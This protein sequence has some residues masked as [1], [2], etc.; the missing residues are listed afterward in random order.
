MK[1]LVLVATLGAL[2]ACSQPETASESELTEEVAVAET[3]S[4]A[5]DGMPSVGN[6]RVTGDDGTTYTQELRA[7]GTYTNTEE[8]KDDVTG[9][10]EQKSPEVFCTTK[11][12]EGAEQECSDENFGDDG[13]WKSVDQADGKV[14]TVERIES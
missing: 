11:G 5:L 1:N 6:Y 13:V 9:T 3:G 7:D 10:W 4:T 12:D 8:G 14:Y 2:A